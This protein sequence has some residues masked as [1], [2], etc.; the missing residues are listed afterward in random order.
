MFSSKTSPGTGDIIG[1]DIGGTLF[2]FHSMVLAKSGSTYFA[3]HLKNVAYRDERGR[4]VYFIDRS[5]TRFAYVRDFVVSGTLHLPEG[6]NT[7]RRNLRQEAEYFGLEGLVDILKVSRT[8]SPDQSNKGILYWLGTSRGNAG[9]VGGYQ[10]PY[11]TGA[12]HVGR[13]KEELSSC[14]STVC[15]S[16]AVQS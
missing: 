15:I 8:I 11:K 13:Y 14:G 9:G 12:V 7:L 5:P 2:Y 3:S 10:N 16:E 4:D 6:D 1:L